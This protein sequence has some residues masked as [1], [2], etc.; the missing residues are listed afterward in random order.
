MEYIT[1]FSQFACHFLL[2][3][4]FIWNARD[5]ISVFGQLLSAA[6]MVRDGSYIEFYS[7]TLLL[8]NI[9]I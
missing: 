5:V 3:V 6:Y 1:I 2:K 9:V 7:T 4:A 8:K